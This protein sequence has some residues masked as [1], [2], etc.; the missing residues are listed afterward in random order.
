VTRPLL[1]INQQRFLA[2]PSEYQAEAQYLGDNYALVG[3]V[4]NGV[5][6]RQRTKVVVELVCRSPEA[7]LRAVGEMVRHQGLLATPTLAVCAD[8][9]A[10]C[11][12]RQKQRVALFQV[13]KKRD[14]SA[15]LAVRFMDQDYSIPESEFRSMQIVTIIQQLINLQKESSE[16]ALSIPVRAVP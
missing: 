16:R 15:L 14:R 4:V 12:G 1:S 10:N 13:A 6:E 11:T 7:V 5:A 9:T 3:T 2:A 8:G